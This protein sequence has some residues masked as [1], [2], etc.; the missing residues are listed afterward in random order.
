MTEAKSHK[1]G[2]VHNIATSPSILQV[3]PKVSIVLSCPSV[4]S[5]KRYD[6]CMPQIG[7]AVVKV[8]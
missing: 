7:S 1:D 8:L 5:N 2:F 4:T 6:N 3:T